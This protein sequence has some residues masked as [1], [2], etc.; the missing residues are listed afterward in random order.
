MIWPVQAIHKACGFAS[1]CAAAGTSVPGV[2]SIGALVIYTNVNVQK[3]IPPS[4]Q[5]G[6]VKREKVGHIPCRRESIGWLLGLHPHH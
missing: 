4:M 3:Q 2:M 6:Q 5:F 1:G